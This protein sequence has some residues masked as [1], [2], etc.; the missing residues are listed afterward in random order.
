MASMH[1]LVV[2]HYETGYSRAIVPHKLY[3]YLGLK[4]P[5]LA[6]GEP[7]GEMARIINKT[8]TGVTVSVSDH[9]GLFRVIDQM[10]SELNVQGHLTSRG[11]DEEISRFEIQYL[12]KRLATTIERAI[13]ART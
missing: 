9:D 2:L 5:I 11:S 7:D 3:H 10:C 1:S 13:Q 6:I 12:T 8:G 4:K